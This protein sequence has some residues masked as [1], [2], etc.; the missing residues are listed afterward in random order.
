MTEHLNAHQLSVGSADVL[1]LYL[2]E[3]ISHLVHV[4]LTCQH[5]HVGKLGV[6]LQRLGIADVELC[7]QMNLLSDFTTVR[8]D[9]HVRRNDSRN[10]S[11]LGSIDYLAHQLYVL[12]VDD[13]VDGQIALHAVLGTDG[14]N[15]VQVVDGEMIGRVRAHVELLHSEVDTVGTCLYGSLKAFTRTHGRHYLVI[16]YGCIIHNVQNY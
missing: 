12:V 11:L 6:E 9:S 10:L 8:H 15:V 7:R 5:H 14:S 4:Q 16:S 13:G 2:L 3:D 1:L